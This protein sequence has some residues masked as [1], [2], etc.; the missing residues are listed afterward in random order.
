MKSGGGERG[1]MCINFLSGKTS[2]FLGFRAPSQNITVT[3][4]LF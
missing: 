2:V 3:K 1:F 4:A